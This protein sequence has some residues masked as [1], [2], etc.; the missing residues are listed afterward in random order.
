MKK[1]ISVLLI[2]VFLLTLCLPALAYDGHNTEVSYRY[3]P[4]TPNYTVS[5]PEVWDIQLIS[6]TDYNSDR[7][8]HIE[9][10]GAVNLNG[11]SVI[12]TI[13]A[14]QQSEISGEPLN[15]EITE[16][17]PYPQYLRYTLIN[18]TLA[19]GFYTSYPNGELH[20]WQTGVGG[21]W[22]IGDRIAEFDRNGV[23]LI[24]FNIHSWVQWKDIA[25]NVPYKGIITFGI[26]LGEGRVD[27]EWE[28]YIM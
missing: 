19:N 2:F 26:S 11:Q 13:D 25:P 15:L 17:A 16:E 18:E 5:I 21:G 12:I 24:S 22:D 27:W 8:A 9:V 23:Q 10:S 14:T 4:A 28:S 6:E 3:I 7:F 20:L 1:K